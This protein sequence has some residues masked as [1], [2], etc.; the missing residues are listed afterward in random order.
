MQ[1]L[2]CR[3]KTKAKEL[4]SAVTDSSPPTKVVSGGFV[5]KGKLTRYIACQ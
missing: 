4:E 3:Y 2:Y 5:R 1:T